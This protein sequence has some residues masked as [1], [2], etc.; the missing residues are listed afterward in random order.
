MS[1]GRIFLRLAFLVVWVG[2]ATGSLAEP[3][4]CSAET[5]VCAVLKSA[6]AAGTGTPATSGAMR[7]YSARGSR[8]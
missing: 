6:S 1:D 2:L 4:E 5:R 8:A 7:S 3:T